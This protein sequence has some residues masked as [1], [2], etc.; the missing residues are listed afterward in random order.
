V[1]LDRNWQERQSD[2]PCSDFPRFRV[3]S[4]TCQLD[5][6]K[7]NEIVAMLMSQSTPIRSPFLLFCLFFLGPRIRYWLLPPEYVKQFWSKYTAELLIW[8]GPQKYCLNLYTGKK[9]GNTP[10]G[11]HLLYTLSAV[12]ACAMLC[13]PTRRELH[14]FWW[15]RVIGYIPSTIFWKSVSFMQIFYKTLLTL[16]ILGTYIEGI[17]LPG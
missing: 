2:F 16:L 9:N 1:Q 11:W 7:S 12:Q 8:P 15:R 10:F 4:P 5:R 6:I 13:K 17:S 3:L 14:G